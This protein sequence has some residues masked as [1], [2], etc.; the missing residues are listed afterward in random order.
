[1][2]GT[3]FVLSGSHENVLYKTGDDL[4]STDGIRYQTACRA[5]W[6]ARKSYQ[7]TRKCERLLVRDGRL[8][9]AHLSLSLPV[10]RRGTGASLMVD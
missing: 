10:C 8:N 9:S 6:H 5:S 2:S 4:D 7:E 1:M 3:V